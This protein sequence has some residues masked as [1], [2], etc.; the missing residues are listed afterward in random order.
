M[1][2]ANAHLFCIGTY[3]YKIQLTQEVYLIILANKLSDIYLKTDPRFTLHEC[4]LRKNEM[5]ITIRL[6]A[7]LVTNSVGGFRSTHAKSET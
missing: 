6:N 1:H 3:L 4:V 5:I 7:Y 2:G